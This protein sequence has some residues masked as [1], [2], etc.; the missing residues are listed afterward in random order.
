MRLDG[1]RTTAISLRRRDLRGIARCHASSMRRRASPRF[2]TQAGGQAFQ[3]PLFLPHGTPNTAEHGRDTAPYALES[4]FGCRLRSAG[5]P[6]GVDGSS[7]NRPVRPWCS[8]DAFLE[9][10][11]LAHDFLPLR[12]GDWGDDKLRAFSCKRHG[13]WPWQV[14][15]IPLSMR[16]RPGEAAKR[17][18]KALTSQR[19]MRGAGNFAECPFTMRKL[20]YLDRQPSRLDCLRRRD[21]GR[22][23][24]RTRRNQGHD[25]RCTANPG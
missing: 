7:R 20:A 19:L 24:Y 4:V 12:C 21:H 13:F 25:Q 5:D 14:A 3:T 22:W 18:S 17:Q 16:V 2:R 1:R 8:I 10:S 11:I 23:L 15:E 9:C 6:L